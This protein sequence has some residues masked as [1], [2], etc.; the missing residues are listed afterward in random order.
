MIL[1]CISCLRQTTK[2]E[3]DRRN[4]NT[5]KCAR[6]G[7]DLIE[8]PEPDEDDEQPTRSH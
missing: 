6:C 3:A 1:T 8:K 5:G 4:F 2:L 7:G